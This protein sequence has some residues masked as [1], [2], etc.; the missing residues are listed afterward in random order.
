MFQRK[1]DIEGIR[2]KD[3][4]SRDG[5]SDFSKRQSKKHYLRAL[6]DVFLYI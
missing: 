3:K 6:F 2:I 1:A 4:N 5:K